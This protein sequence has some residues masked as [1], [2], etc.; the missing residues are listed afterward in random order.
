MAWYLFRR[1]K[2]GMQ[3]ACLVCLPVL[4]A[5]VAAAGRSLQA[6]LVGILFQ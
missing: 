4:H 2:Q 5:E 3:H 6:G 1:L